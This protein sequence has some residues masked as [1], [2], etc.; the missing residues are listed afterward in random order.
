MASNPCA[1]LFS[2]LVDGLS[3]N[4]FNVSRGLEAYES[5]FG[6]EFLS[7]VS[8]L[9]P[10]E[11][12]IDMGAGHARAMTEYVYPE[13]AGLPDHIRNSLGLRQGQHAQLTA[14]AYQRPPLKEFRSKFPGL[15]VLDE[16]Q[17]KYFSGRYV[18]QIPDAEL[19]GAQLITDVFGPTAYSTRLDEV[20]SK[21]LRLI[22]KDGTIF[23]RSNEIGILLPSGKKLPL[24]DWLKSLSG[25][26][27]K[28]LDRWT[29]SLKKTSSF[30]G[31]PRLILKEMSGSTPP[32]RVFEVLDISE[33]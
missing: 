20:L 7:V 8:R 26:E 25:L 33:N 11:R 13:N 18:E 28:A 1:V 21:Y 4:S 27:V 6:P 23:I 2:N 3:K 14:V 16:T 10:K 12:W 22:D 15:P 5:Q 30:E 29:F 24:V 19:G 17:L 9:G 32:R 31:L